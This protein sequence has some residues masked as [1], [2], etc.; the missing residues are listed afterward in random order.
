MVEK[1]HNTPEQLGDSMELIRNIAIGLFGN[2]LI[3]GLNI[4]WKNDRDKFR[5]LCIGLNSNTVTPEIVTAKIEEIGLD[6]IPGV[7]IKSF[8]IE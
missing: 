7:N 1:I 5:L 3:T 2:H 4:A 6:R 8:K